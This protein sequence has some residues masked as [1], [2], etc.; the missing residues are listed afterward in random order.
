MQPILSFSRLILF[1]GTSLLLLNAAS[2]ERVEHLG[3]YAEWSEDTL[4]L[5]NELVQRQWQIE[6]SGLLRPVSFV[7]KAGDAEWLRRP[8]RQPAPFPAVPPVKE[9]R[10]LEFRIV[11][12]KL[13]PVEAE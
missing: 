11:K 1:T 2:A 6:A 8:S 5:G 10:E 13:S 3:C 12:E 4:T 7:D 9:A